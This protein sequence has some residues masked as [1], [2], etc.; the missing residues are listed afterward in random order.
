MFSTTCQSSETKHLHGLTFWSVHLQHRLHRFT[1]STTC[2]SRRKLS[3]KKNVSGK[4]RVGHWI[5][6]HRSGHCNLHRMNVEL[7]RKINCEILLDCII[8]IFILHNL[9]AKKNICKRNYNA[10]FPIIFFFFHELKLLLLE[11]KLLYPYIFQYLSSK[12]F[13]IASIT[14]MSL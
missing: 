5:L 8:C 3:F 4:H 11:V 9:A 7:S 10:N 14:W 6:L 2:K 12:T 1:C 13:N